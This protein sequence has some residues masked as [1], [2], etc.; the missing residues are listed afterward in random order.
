MPHPLPG[1]P[2]MI[3]QTVLRLLAALILAPFLNV[4]V[5]FAEAADRPGITVFAA[6]SLKTALDGLADEYQRAT[7]VTV[8]LS[9]AASSALAKQIEAGAPAEL[10]ISADTD[11]MDYLAAKSLIQNDSRVTLLG[12]SLVLIVPAGSAST[13]V[14]L[15]PGL[16]LLPLLGTDGRLAVALVDSV[17]AG[18]YARAALT[19]LGAWPALEPR[20]VQAENVR[21]A[22]TLVARAEAPAGI[23]YATDALAEP[24]V[25]QLG[26]F[27]ADS[28]PAIVYPAALTGSAG[29]SARAFMTWLSGPVAT[30]RFAGLGFTVPQRGS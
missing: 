24:K 22:L 14:A 8:S 27:P 5:T 23:V 4:S 9:Y 29:P 13:P 21:A 30:A 17:P 7:G 28:H 11:W 10:F 6:A 12:N 16:D 26:T 18:R 15:K 19:S 1:V 3:R 25:R 20:L 2:F